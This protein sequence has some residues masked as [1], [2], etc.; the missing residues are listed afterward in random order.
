ML[1][2]VRYRIRFREVTAAGDASLL[3]S[4]TGYLGSAWRGAFGHALRKTVCVTGLPDC[5]AC[6][7]VDSCPYPTTFDNRPPPTAKKLTRYPTAPNPY[8][9]APQDRHVDSREGTVNLGI[10][11]AGHANDHLPS[12]VR[13]LERAGREG[14]TSRRVKLRL[15]DIQTE[16]ADEAGWAT[17]GEAG[18][19]LN[20][21]RPRR[22]T[23]PPSPA[24]V[25]VRLVTPLRIKR[26]ERF[27]TP[28]DFDFRAFV[29][30]LLRRLSLLTYFYGD[31]PL[32]TD[33]AGLL[34]RAEKVPVADANLRWRDW[35][36]Y[37]SHQRTRRWAG[38]WEPLRSPIQHSNCSGL[39]FG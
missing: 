32:E 20:A 12:I 10:T 2:L 19:S 14:L 13:A 34:R 16:V 4:R 29:A 33:F 27:V 30:N 36:R 9:L 23:A 1:S 38:S 25:Q 3:S 21:V 39:A 35:A 7:L 15:M 11:L 24:A 17:I 8:V 28:A 31:E 18:G 22:P 37:S 26:R 6:S 5:A